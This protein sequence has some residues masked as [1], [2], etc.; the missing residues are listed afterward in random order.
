MR[1]VIFKF[2]Y[3]VSASMRK[4]DKVTK[5]ITTSFCCNIFREIKMQ[6]EVVPV[7]TFTAA[8]K[9]RCQIRNSKI[10]KKQHLNK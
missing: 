6:I 3:T 10:N 4:S 7:E 8:N 2:V 5:F 1:R 9:N